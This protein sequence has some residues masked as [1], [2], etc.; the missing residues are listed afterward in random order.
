MTAIYSNTDIYQSMDFPNVTDELDTDVI[1]FIE[2]SGYLH[3]LAAV[4]SLKYL[5]FFI[6]QGINVNCRNSV[7]I[8]MLTQ[9]AFSGH[10]DIVQSL[11]ENG[12]D[13][14]LICFS[15][16]FK[17]IELATMC[18]HLNIVKYLNECGANY[19]P[20]DLYF[21][22]KISNHQEIIEYLEKN[23]ELTICPSDFN[24]SSPLEVYREKHSKKKTS[25]LNVQ[26]CKQIL[27][28]T[29]VLGFLCLF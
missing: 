22:A 6:D 24:N 28:C 16:K 21:E 2:S 11:V 27:F 3:Y 23:S 14:E 26:K 12:A 19:Y 18:G 4:G 8:T 10:L 15:T 7:G 17:A 9:A 29:M 1:P 25:I 13:T 5:E 20:D